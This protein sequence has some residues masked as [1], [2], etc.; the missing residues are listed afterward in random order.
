VLNSRRF[1]SA[2]ESGGRTVLLFIVAIP[3]AISCPQGGLSLWNPCLWVNR[4]RI[5]TVSPEIKELV[6]EISPQIAAVG[7]TVRLAIVAIHADS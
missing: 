5:D 6:E 3:F 7:D 2:L 4:T 1:T